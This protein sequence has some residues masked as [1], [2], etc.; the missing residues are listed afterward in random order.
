[1]SDVFDTV[2][3][4]ESYVPYCSVQALAVLTLDSVIHR[5]SHY[6]ADKYSEKQ[7]RYLVD[8]LIRL[9]KNWNQYVISMG[10]R[11]DSW[12]AAT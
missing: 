10:R 5:I 3:V 2:A 1:M 9:L 6:P 11:T 4:L 8:S 12:F 7:L